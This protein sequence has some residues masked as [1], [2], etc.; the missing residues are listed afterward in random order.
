MDTFLGVPVE[1]WKE[2][3]LAVAIL[4]GAAVVGRLVVFVI[5]RVFSRLVGRTATSFDNALVSAVRGPLFWLIMFIGLQLALGQLSFL[6]AN[7]RESRDDLIFVL[8][9]IVGAALAS[10]LVSNMMKWYGQEMAR[11]TRSALDEQ[12]V[13]FVRRLL[14][15]VV[16]IIAFIVVMSHFGIDVSAF[17]TTL[18]IGSLAVALAAKETLADMISGFVII[19]DRPFSIGERVEI[20]ELNTWGD[21][22]DIGLR[23]TRIR[24]RDNRMVVVPNSVIGKSLVV[25]HSDPSTVYRVQ[26]HVGV[27]YGPNLNHAREVMIEAVRTQDWVMHDRRVEALFVEFGD[28]AAIFRV[29]C[30]IEHYEETRR[31]MDKLNSCLYDALDAAAIEMPDPTQTLYHRVAAKDRDGLVAVLKEARNAA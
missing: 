17:V 25:N 11:R 2:I 26:T 18:G 15:A 3:G 29:R 1:Y 16:W 4:V 9:V 13:P 23:S 21:V 5:D 31:I 7:L 12:T 30:W 19:T 28:S 24:T 20:Q 14:I 6:P 8:Y 10:G 27:A 22:T